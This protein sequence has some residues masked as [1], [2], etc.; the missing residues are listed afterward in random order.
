MTTGYP[1][2]GRL[3]SSGPDLYLGRY[4]PVSPRAFCQDERDM[5]F[6]PGSSC[7]DVLGIGPGRY[8]LVVWR[9][10][11]AAGLMVLRLGRVSLHTIFE[12]RTSSSR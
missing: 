11:T 4:T 8:F 3:V 5:A 10:Y 7:L 6:L 1:S 9:C 2:R 12:A